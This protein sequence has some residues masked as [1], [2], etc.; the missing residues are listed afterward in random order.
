MVQLDCI[1]KTNDIADW[2]I[3][4]INF[5]G[6]FWVSPE[7]STTSSPS[8][9]AVISFCSN[10]FHC[11]GSSHEGLTA[12]QLP[13]GK[14]IP[15]CLWQGNIWSSSF[16][17]VWEQG[18]SGFCP[19]FQLPCCMEPVGVTSGCSPSTLWA[20]MHQY[21]GFRH[22]QKWSHWISSMCSCWNLPGYSDWSIMTCCNK[23]TPN[24][25]TFSLDPCFRE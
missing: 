22:S 10:T 8:G 17:G 20:N 11:S 24:S 6:V 5:T 13:R 9:P 25:A 21:L 4:S 7:D 1:S 2:L 16:G 19:S 3:C 14:C 15:W 23:H 18:I 12:L